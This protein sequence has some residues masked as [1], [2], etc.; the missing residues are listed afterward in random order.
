MFGP[1][2]RIAFKIRLASKWLV[3]DQVSAELESQVN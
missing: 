1:R 3:S 2:N